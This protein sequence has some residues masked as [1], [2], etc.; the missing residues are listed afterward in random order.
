MPDMID[1]ID[2]ILASHGVQPQDLF[3]RDRA[4]KAPP[5]VNHEIELPSDLKIVRRNTRHTA[6]HLLHVSNAARHLERLPE[7]GESIHAIMKG[8]YN[9]WDLV[10]A[11]FKLAGKCKIDALHVATLSFN[12]QNAI[13][14]LEMYDRGDVRAVVFLCSCYFE[15]TSAQEYAIIDVGLRRR[16][17]QCQAARNHA[18]IIL[19]AMA[20]GRRLIIESSA[21]LRSCRNVEQFCM[22]ADADLYEFHRQWIERMVIDAREQ[23]QKAG[24]KGDRRS[25]IAPA[26]QS[27]R[28]Q[29]RRNVRRADQSPGRRQVATGNPADRAAG[30]A[31]VAT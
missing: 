25:Q 26:P 1:D 24:S 17:Q 5:R 11:V 3:V 2:T 8:N 9:A 27:K 20:D 15:Q 7:P 31:A 28:E 23:K 19:F 22:T 29:T 16:G 30:S 18:K 6:L 4:K 13:E 21:N 12:Q 10:P 14:L